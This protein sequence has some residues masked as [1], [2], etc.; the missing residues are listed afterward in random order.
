MKAV[1]LTEERFATY[2]SWWQARGLPV[3]IPGARAILL[4]QNGELVSGMMLYSTDGPYT[5]FEHFAVSPK[6]PP[7]LAHRALSMTLAIAEGL[8]AME[9][10]VPLVMAGKKGIVSLLERTGYKRQTDLGVFTK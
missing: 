8:C 3:P 10:K 6:A 4:D 2:A 9:A 5:F 1:P 7:G